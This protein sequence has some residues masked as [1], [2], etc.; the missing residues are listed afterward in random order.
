VSQ[1]IYC[2]RVNPVHACVKRAV[3]RR[4]RL[5]IVLC[6]QE[7]C[8]FPPPIAHAPK[9]MAVNSISELPSRFVVPKL[10]AL[11]LP[12]MHSQP[13]KSHEFPRQPATQCAPICSGLQVTSSPSFFAAPQ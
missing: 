10:S 4:D 3:D 8:Q 11:M 5:V 13:H 12:R 7:N 1:P 6:P 9:P 2:S